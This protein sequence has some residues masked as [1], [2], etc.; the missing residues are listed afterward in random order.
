M[1]VT[2]CPLVCYTHTQYTLIILRL[3]HNE[4]LP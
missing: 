2:K 3:S 4:K 1:L